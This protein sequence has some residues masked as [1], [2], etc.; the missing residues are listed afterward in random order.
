MSHRYHPNPEKNDPEDAILYD[1]CAD[2]AS[3]AK[4]PGLNLDATNWWKM[5]DR[6]LHVEIDG[7]EAYRSNN[8]AELGRHLYYMYIVLERYTAVDPKF[9]IHART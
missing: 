6:M 8:E 9:L 7:N 4:S 3:H 1:D 5:W 2:C